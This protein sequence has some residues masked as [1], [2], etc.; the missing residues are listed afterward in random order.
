MEKY[1]LFREKEEELNNQYKI[2]DYIVTTGNHVYSAIDLKTNQP[3]AI[4]EIS[5]N[6]QLK[7]DAQR[8]YNELKTF[9]LLDHDN[10]TKFITFQVTPT[11]DNFCNFT[12]FFV[13]SELLKFSLDQMI[14]NTENFITVEHRRL[15]LYQILKV[16]K[17]L[18]SANIIVRSMNPLNLFIDSSYKVK[19]LFFAIDKFQ[20][21]GKMVERW[22]KAP[23][24]L[25]INDCLDASADIWSVGC[26]FYTLITK[27]V[28][29]QGNTLLEQVNSIISKIG[30]LPEDDLTYIEK[31]ILDGI[32]DISPNAIE[33]NWNKIIPN[34][35]GEEVDLI[36]SM[37]V[38]RPSKRISVD[39]ALKHPYFND[40][41]DPS[42]IKTIDS[43]V[44]Q[45]MD[46][47]KV[48]DFKQLIWEEVQSKK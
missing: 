34:G 16:L 24:I 10:I 29:F 44:L 46:D 7:N 4:Q 26:I 27:K 28:L 14:S 3:V 23:E 25:F 21:P 48:D 38:W 12:N 30:N 37:L 33:P 1:I 6:F 45:E 9:K 43:I 20:K 47:F 17:Y 5:D 8:V 32:I 41:Y 42:D 13:V 22:Y 2:E 39:D 18:H 15:I 31:Q 40:V 36:K 35:L 19:F 11:F